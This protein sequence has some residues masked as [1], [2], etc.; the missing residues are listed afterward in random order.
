MTSTS[1]NTPPTSSKK[2]ARTSW[3]LCCTRST[4][5]M[6][7]ASTSWGWCTRTSCCVWMRRLRHLICCECS[8]PTQRYLSRTPSYFWSSRTSS[9]HALSRWLWTSWRL[10]LVA[11]Q[12]QD[13]DHPTSVRYSNKESWRILATWQLKVSRKWLV[14]LFSRCEAP[15]CCTRFCCPDCVPFCQSSH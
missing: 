12:S 8:S 11:S 6:R 9:Y 10:V 3:S 15:R 2:W 4:L 5:C 14:G 7:E 13:L 1:S